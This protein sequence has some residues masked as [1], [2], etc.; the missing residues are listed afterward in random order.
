M[1]GMNSNLARV[2]SDPSGYSG[3]GASNGSMYTGLNDQWGNPI[4]VS[5]ANLMEVPPPANLWDTGSPAD[6]NATG[7]PEAEDPESVMSY[8]VTGDYHFGQ[9]ALTSA[10]TNTGGN[11]AGRTVVGLYDIPGNAA[12]GGQPGVTGASTASWYNPVTRALSLKPAQTLGRVGRVGRVGRA[13][14]RVGR[15]ACSN[16]GSLGDDIPFYDPT[17]QITTYGPDPGNTYD[18][19]IY[20]G[21]TPT[22]DTGA[23]ALPNQDYVPT[24][25][26]GALVPGG[27]SAGSAAGGILGPLLKV[28]TGSNAALPPGYTRN[29]AGQ[30]IDPQGRI[31]AQAGALALTPSA[32]TQQMLLI[33]GGVLLLFMMKKKGR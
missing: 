24:G 1:N 8:G 7:F 11:Y 18:P 12:D 30:V 26:S 4:F 17:T 20:T 31:V 3:Y 14:G 28:L 32:Q 9:G 22:T 19:S 29:A 10:Q 33:G 13:V 15:M 6:F 16:L 21:A 5:S 23:G 27:S 2:G 25:S